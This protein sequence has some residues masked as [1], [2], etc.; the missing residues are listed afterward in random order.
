M[1]ST[2]RIAVFLALFFTTGLLTGKAYEHFLPAFKQQFYSKPMLYKTSDKQLQKAFSDAE[3]RNLNWQELLPVSEREAIDDYR[4]PTEDEFVRQITE[5][6]QIATD[7][8]YQPPPP[9]IDIVDNLVGQAVS[10][11]GF[12]VP[13]DMNEDRSIKSYFIVPYYGAC[14][15]YP[16]PPPNQMIFVELTDGFSAL[17][18]EQAYTVSGFLDQGLFEDPLGTSAYILNV[19]SIQT[20]YGQPDDVREH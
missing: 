14:I 19:T 16:P 20:F 11:S 6:I 7:R 13:I 2:L 4:E 3:K 5:A 15:H 8:S 1:N 18:L 12:I 17:D 9:S 10:I